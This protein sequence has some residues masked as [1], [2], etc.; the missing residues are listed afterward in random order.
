M[1]ATHRRH[2]INAYAIGQGK[3]TLLL[4]GDFGKCLDEFICNPIKLLMAQVTLYDEHLSERLEHRP[5]WGA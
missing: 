5:G 2:H 3:R 4:R 1:I